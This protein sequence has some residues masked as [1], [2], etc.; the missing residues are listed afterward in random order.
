MGTYIKWI[1]EVR[2][3]GRWR[4][5]EA[6]AE[7]DQNYQ[8]FFALSGVREL[9]VR[10]RGYTQQ[11]FFAPR[12]ELPTD[13]SEEARGILSWT[14]FDGE[15]GICDY[16]TLAELEACDWSWTVSN[17]DEVLA[18]L[19]SLGKPDDVRALWTFD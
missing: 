3:S 15:P 7:P 11:P 5:V 12:W 14:T 19:R 9:A 18:E 16:R 10:E 1:V 13:A 2:E 6:R 8:L 4:V 17:M